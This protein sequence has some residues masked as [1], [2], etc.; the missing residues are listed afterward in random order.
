MKNVLVRRMRPEELADAVGVWRRSR[1]D[2]VPDIEA[3]AGHSYEDDLE[4]FAEAVVPSFDVWVALQSGTIVGIMAKKGDD[5]DKL[6]VEP[7]EQRRGIGKRL[8]EIAKRDSP[9][10]LTVFTHQVNA[11]ARAFYEANGF[12][13]AEFGI[14]PPPESEPDIKYVWVPRR[15][16]NAA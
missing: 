3:R 6:Y 8:L 5:L 13:A 16:E 10:G 1:V 11:R 12:A 2:A 4:H 7:S 14:S 9:S 15:P